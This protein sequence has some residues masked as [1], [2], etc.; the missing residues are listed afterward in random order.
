MTRAL[1]TTEVPTFFGPPD[2]PLFG[3]VHLPADNAI[4]GGVLICPS[5]GKEAMDSARLHRALA[6]G[7]AGRGFAVLRFDYLGTG[8]SA[9]GQLRDDAVVNWIASVGHAL[10]YLRLIGAE[11]ATA[12][13][14]RAG[15]LILQEYLAQSGRPRKVER[16]VYL[17]PASTGRR[18]LREHATLFR[19]AVGEDAD[20]PGQ[21]SVLGG[22][23]SHRAATEFATL[24]MAVGPV[25]AHGVDD[26]LLV[27]RP[28]ETD[29]HLTALAAAE[30]VD[31]VVAAGLPECARPW[32]NLL[33]VP[34]AAVDTIV[35]WVAAKSPTR[36]YRAIPQ[37]L[38]TVTM[39]AQRPGEI[40]VVESIE[41]I[42]LD[43]LFA[44]RTRSRRRAVAPFRTVVFFVTAKDLHVG[45]TREWVELSRRIAADGAQA[46]RWDPA[47]LGLSSHINRDPYRNVFSKADLVDAVAVARR[48]CRDST[49]L[50]LVGV[51]SGG[52]YAAQVARVT[53]ARSAVVVNLLAWNWRVVSTV[54]SQWSIRKRAL[55]FSASIES[56]GGPG[57]SRLSRLKARLNPTREAAKS[58][59]HNHFPRWL[60]RM[61]CWLGLV[62][63]PEHVLTTL[64]RRGTAVTVIASPE[65]GKQF[66]ANGGRGAVERLRGAPRP[67]RLIATAT[68]DHPAYHPV[69][70]AAI[71]EAVLPVPTVSAREQ[72]PH[73]TSSARS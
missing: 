20:T 40:D 42:G 7:L 56:A 73:A 18:Y 53:G 31:S 33:P 63:L 35:E 25:S 22:R 15:C 67:P 14:I 48:A 26:V 23:F 6:E 21:V 54:L 69:M 2:S 9:F 38:S 28:A 29:Q 60:L 37:Y 41:R 1:T 16:V 68:G 44:I 50:E 8:D 51:C 17:D 62:W 49:E 4:R 55:N 39:P 59:M 32:E 61:L 47:G 3:V 72:T 70:L 10:D 71:R 13:G 11:S 65:D 27:G 46:L 19:V 52:W 36:A 34:K 24:R 58:I 66:T 5:L 43:G 64:A 30:G 57:V 45:P 12:I